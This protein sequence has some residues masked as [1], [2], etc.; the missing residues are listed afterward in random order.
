MKTGTTLG[1]RDRREASVTPCSQTQEAVKIPLAGARAKRVIKSPFEGG[2]AKRRGMSG[3][4]ALPEIQHPPK[5]PFKGG[6]SFS[7]IR[8]AIFLVLCG[9]LFAEG[10]ASKFQEGM[11]PGRVTHRRLEAPGQAAR[12]TPEKEL[13]VVYFAFDSAWLSDEARAALKPVAALLKAEPDL[14][15]MLQGHTCSDGN[16]DYNEALGLRRAEAVKA[17]L[18]EQGIG[19]KRIGA[20]T[21][22]ESRPIVNNR[23][24]AQKPFNRRV[25]IVV[26]HWKEGQP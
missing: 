8:L 10:C 21:L 19:Q 20:S 7:R 15:A 9:V 23:D 18:V 13:P 25:E 14:Y 12:Y 5:S 1:C 26:Y 24:E 4:K 11:L 17:Y 16:A 2:G 3:S 6:L 22:G